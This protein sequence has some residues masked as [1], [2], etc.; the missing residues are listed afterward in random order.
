MLDP[1]VILIAREEVE[2]QDISR[3]LSMLK[4][5]LSNPETAKKH[6]EKI[7]IAFHGYDDDTRELFEIPEVRNSVFKL[8]EAFP[9]WFY[10]LSKNALGLQ[11]LVLCF[12]PPYL[13]EEAKA[14]IFPE[15]LQPLLLERW[16]PAMNQV[17]EFVKMP[18]EEIVTSYVA[19]GRL[20]DIEGIEVRSPDF[21][22]N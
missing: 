15:R 14:E 2:S 21:G 7:D 11:A 1:I 10:F 9:Y 16:F 17:C 19:N 6:F 13:T 18:E 20:P 4:T 3:I 5:L 12:L 22:S 8:D